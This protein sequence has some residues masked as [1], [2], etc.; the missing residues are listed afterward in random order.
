MTIK[1]HILIFTQL[2]SQM[3]SKY[4]HSNNSKH[5]YRIVATH[6]PL[7]KS[8]KTNNFFYYRGYLQT[9]PQYFL[10]KILVRIHCTSVTYN[11]F[12][13]YKTKHTFT[14]TAE[15][16]TETQEFIHISCSMWNIKL[17]DNNIY[18]GPITK[19]HAKKQYCWFVFNLI[20]FTITTTY[21][22]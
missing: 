13:I 19:S 3:I 12:I 22:S 18:T 9:E 11:W 20:T 4:K 5:S 2:P 16:V 7:I 10:L 1:G 8:R 17:I 6:S 21:F 14:D 15:K